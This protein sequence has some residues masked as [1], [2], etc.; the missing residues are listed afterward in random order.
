[1]VQKTICIIT[2]RGVTT[3]KQEFFNNINNP[4]AKILVNKI[5]Y[6]TNQTDFQSGPLYGDIKI[7]FKNNNHY[8]H[9]NYIG[10]VKAYINKKTSN[11]E[12]ETYKK[13][14]QLYLFDIEWFKILEYERPKGN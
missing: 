2:L 4:N 6:T 8:I 14:N 5:V 12:F 9:Y 13:N 3:L 7:V 11:I 1:M 10:K